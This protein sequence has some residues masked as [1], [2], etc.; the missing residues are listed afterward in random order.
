MSK[1]HDHSHQPHGSYEHSPG[2]SS[3]RG[4]HRDWRFWAAVVLMLAA[5]GAYVATMDE[6]IL[7]GGPVEPEVPADAE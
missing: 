4:I 2:H 1:H 7:P 6:A 3:K 5:M